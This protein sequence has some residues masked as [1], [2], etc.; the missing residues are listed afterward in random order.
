MDHQTTG[1]SLCQPIVPPYYILKIVGFLDRTLEEGLDNPHGRAIITSNSKYYCSWYGKFEL[2]LD[3][4]FE[5][6]TV[7]TLYALEEGLDNP[8]GRVIITGNSKSAYSRVSTRIAKTYSVCCLVKKKHPPL[9]Y[10]DPFFYYM[11]I[12]IITI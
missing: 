1:Q 11:E 7:C 3:R 5:F 8:H 10:R 9:F 6:G 4:N 2:N 12:Q